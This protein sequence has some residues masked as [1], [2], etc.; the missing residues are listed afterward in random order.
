MDRNAMNLEVDTDTWLER[1]E[2]LVPFVCD[3][4]FEARGKPFRDFFG[5]PFPTSVLH[6][7]AEGDGACATWLLRLDE[8]SACGRLLTGALGMPSFRRHFDSAYGEAMERFDAI[9]GREVRDEGSG[10]SEDV[11]E[12]L[13]DLAAALVNFHRLGAAAELVQQWTGAEHGLSLD[14]RGDT[15][16]GEALACLER[17]GHKLAAA[18]G[19]DWRDL[20]WFS[21][22]EVVDPDFDFDDLGGEAASRRE[23]LIHTLSTYPLDDAEMAAMLTLARQEGREG[24]PAT[25]G[26]TSFAGR[27]A[28]AALQRIDGRLGLLAASAGMRTLHGDV[29][30]RPAEPIYEAT[31]H[32]VADPLGDSA[33]E[34]ASGEILV[35]AST[36]PDFVSLMSRAG[37]IV[38]DQ[39]GATSHAAIVARELRI[40][41]IV[42]TRVATAVLRSGQRLRLDLINGTI[43]LAPE[44]DKP[45]SRAGP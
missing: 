32:I 36:S 24:L 9:L 11:R 22:T 40:P 41:C 21:P 43:A 28:P 45:S 26:V 35:A 27:D 15:V 42:G 17:L 31:C 37:A 19:C 29:V 25:V 8:A 23:V 33:S 12:R 1:R 14:E 20:E 44:I 34:L 4:S 3:L 39:A 30:Y 5:F 2:P 13:Q 16:G 6:Y 38:T 18:A 7:H 10:P